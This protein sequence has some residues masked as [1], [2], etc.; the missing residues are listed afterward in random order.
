MKNKNMIRK[1]FQ[2]FAIILFFI[3]FQQSVRKY[4][5]YPVIEQKS[6]TPVKDLP[7]PVVYVCHSSQ[8]NYTKALD[9]GYKFF[10]D[11]MLGIRMNSTNVSWKGKWGK[12]TY[13]DLENILF[14]SDYSSIESKSL[15]RSTNHWNFNERKRSFLFPHGVCLE[16]ENL[17]QH[18][19]IAFEST[20][21]NNIYFVDPARAN[22]IRTEETFD[23]KASIG[24]ISDT[25]YSYRITELEYFVDDN[26]IHDGTSC[27]DYTKSDMSYRE[28][29][30]N[31]LTNEFLATYGC[32]PPWVSTNNSQL[33]CEEE[34]NIEANP[35]K[36]TLLY[37]DI[38]RLVQN[39]EAD[40]FKR[41]LAPCITMKIKLQEV[42]YRSNW[43]KRTYFY[44]RI[45]DWATVYTQVYS[46]DFLSLT[47]DLGSA[48]GLWLGLS[49]LSILDHIL[50]NWIVM[51]KYWKR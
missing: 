1:V 27:T 46:Y 20:D 18:T 15:L 29:L 47:V 45:K 48:L 6:R 22:D 24:P 37:E 39:L 44:A 50:E 34:T 2:T 30:N 28:C 49:C 31:V 16:I 26:S 9:N 12:A 38:L 10:T 19:A 3:Q 21:N 8:Y 13:K 42:S 11:F 25:F 32:L 4:F 33:I 17:L 51:E 7:N 23:A 43:L 40:M 41:C 35:M 14:D 36:K 5:Q